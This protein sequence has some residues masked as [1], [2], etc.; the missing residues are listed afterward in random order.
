MRL[1]CSPGEGQALE[2][3]ALHEYHNGI[4]YWRQALHL[5]W[6]RDSG[7]WRGAHIPTVLTLI[8]FD[9]RNSSHTYN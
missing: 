5:T 3:D 9:S 6:P 4:R 8:S 7:S 1:H 2:A